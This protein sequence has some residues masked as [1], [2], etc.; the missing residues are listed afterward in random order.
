[1]C[2]GIFRIEFKDL[3]G[4]G[5]CGVHATL[6]QIGLGVAY[7]LRVGLRHDRCRQPEQAG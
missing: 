2:R 1:V 6:L 7:T 4:F 5:E 3:C